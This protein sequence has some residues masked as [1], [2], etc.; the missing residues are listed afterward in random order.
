MLKRDKQRIN[1]FRI[2]SNKMVGLVLARR[3]GKE[4]DKSSIKV[5]RSGKSWQ[6]LAK[7]IKV[8]KKLA[9]VGKN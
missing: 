3:W 4:I 7:L 8:G 1:S 5:N 9:K 2:A 6:N